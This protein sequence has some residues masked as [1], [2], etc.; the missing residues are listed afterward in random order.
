LAILNEIEA[1]LL[2]NDPTFKPEDVFEAEESAEN[3]LLHLFAHGVYPSHDSA[4]IAQSYQLHVNVERIRVPEVLFQP[5]II[6][7]DQAGIVE[8]ISDVM[9][10]FEGEARKSLTK[11]C[12][13][14]VTNCFVLPYLSNHRP[15]SLRAAFPRFQI[16]TTD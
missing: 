13:P 14:H 4:D 10:R 6:G 11:V 7:L 2:R 8:T 1:N 15:F 5:S 9:K 12:Q 16:W 3:S